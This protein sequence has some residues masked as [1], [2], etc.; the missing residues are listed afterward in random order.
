MRLADVDWTSS[1]CIFA[2]QPC[3]QHD[4]H[5]HYDEHGYHDEHDERDYHDDHCDDDDD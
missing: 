2:I 3:H 5:N 1:I 4:E